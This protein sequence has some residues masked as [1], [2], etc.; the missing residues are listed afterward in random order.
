[1]RVAV[2]G[3]GVAGLCSTHF[4]KKE[5]PDAEV[6]IFEA[7]DNVGGTWN[8]SDATKDDEFNIPMMTSMYKNLRYLLFLFFYVDNGCVNA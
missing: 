8:Y 6:V 4:L 7:T 5:F 3:A 2:I 1:M